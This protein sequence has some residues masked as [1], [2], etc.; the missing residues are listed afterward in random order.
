M[1]SNSHLLSKNQDILTNTTYNELTKDLSVKEESQKNEEHKKKTKDTSFSHGVYASAI[2]NFF[3]ELGDRS[4]VLI[5]LIFNF[6]DSI[7]LT[8]ICLVAQL[9]MTSFSVLLGSQFEMYIN[10]NFYKIIYTFGFFLF[11]LYAVLQLL[12]YLEE[13][14]CEYKEKNQLENE[15]N[16][17]EQEVK[18]QKELV[19][20]FNSDNLAD[21]FDKQ[22]TLNKVIKI[23]FM[24][25]VSE[26]GDRSNIATLILSIEYSA[27]SV[28]FGN[29]LAHLGGILVAVIIGYVINSSIKLTILKLISSFIFLGFS[30]QMLY[31]YTLLKA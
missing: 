30:I 1:K 3:A 22:L 16:L 6:V 29:V 19:S 15:N 31:S 27:I 25:L 5:I 18:I 7:S 9:S 23:Y 2:L 28:F 12:E 20:K 8:V 21:K 11:L 26:F 10:D 24:I 4:F 14:E 13:K 17:K